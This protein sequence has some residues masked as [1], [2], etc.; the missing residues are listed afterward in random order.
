MDLLN[1]V[2][3]TNADSK[4]LPPGAWLCYPCFRSI[5]KVKKLKDGHRQLIERIHPY[6]KQAGETCGLNVQD[7]PHTPSTPRVRKWHTTAVDHQSPAAK[8]RAITF[9]SS[10]PV[11]RSLASMHCTGNSPSV[12]VSIV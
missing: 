3:K 2:F 10:T 4:V 12:A 9:E 8:R 1:D 6:L 5:E 7:L 11:R